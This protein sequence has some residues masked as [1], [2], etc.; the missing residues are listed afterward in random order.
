MPACSFI[1]I[2]A[3]TAF[4]CTLFMFFL[5]LL[6]LMRETQ[7]V[8]RLGSV[9]LSRLRRVWRQQIRAKLRAA[10]FE[11]DGSWRIS[12][13]LNNADVRERI[14]SSV[15]RWFMTEEPAIA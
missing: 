7:L 12:F 14:G 3:T 15:S 9:A 13:F 10:R 2:T 8:I 4:P 11:H 5:V 1:T 6:A